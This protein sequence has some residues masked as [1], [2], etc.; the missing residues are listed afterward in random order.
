ME[1]TDM[2]PEK[3]SYALRRWIGPVSVLGLILSLSAVALPDVRDGAV[4]PNA[5][6]KNEQRT[7]IAALN[8]IRV[9]FLH[10]RLAERDVLTGFS[11][12]AH[13]AAMGAVTGT[14]TALPDASIARTGALR[15]AID[16]YAAGFGSLAA[17]KHQP[18]PHSVAAIEAVLGQLATGDEAVLHEPVLAMRI[19]ANEMLTGTDPL[20]RDRLA[21]SADTFSARLDQLTI[22]RGTRARVTAAL[23]A[24]EHDVAA[25]SDAMRSAEDKSS[26]AALT[27]EA[28]ITEVDRGLAIAPET[29]LSAFGAAGKLNIWLLG[30]AVVLSL[31]LTAG[32]GFTLGRAAAQYHGIGRFLAH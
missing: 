18:A 20:A 9:G 32:G 13:D 23:A 11:A 25:T 21:R 14:L 28:A 31:L 27:V 12:D 16:D 1:F 17:L 6:L 4:Q 5:N 15:T 22:A 30:A 2:E 7:D 26:R 8:A 10:A 3:S 29:T 24:Y 19:A